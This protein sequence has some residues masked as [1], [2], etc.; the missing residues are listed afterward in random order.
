MYIKMNKDLSKFNDYTPFE[1]INKRIVHLEYTKKDCKDDF[2]I[3]L[4]KFYLNEIKKRYPNDKLETHIIYKLDADYLLDTNDCKKLEEIDNYLRENN[5]HELLVG[6]KNSEFHAHGFRAT[7][8]ANRKLD[9]VANNI[10]NATTKISGETKPLSNYE[11]LM[12]AY[13]Y[14]TN[15]V[16]NE[17]GDIGHVETSHWI[18]VIEG[19]KI[20]CAGY[21]SLFKALC[22]RIFDK[23]EVRVL[24]QSL[25]VFDIDTNE[26]RAGH[27]N[28][29]IF[30]KD[31]KYNIDGLFYIDP[32]WDSRNNTTRVDKQHAYF[33]IPLK[34]I[35]KSTKYTFSF[36][37]F[38]RLYLKQFEE[39]TSLHEN[40]RKSLE[41]DI[42][43]IFANFPYQDR[44]FTSYY[45]ERFNDLTIYS[46]YLNK[47]EIDSIFE[48]TK[49]REKEL[50]EEMKNLLKEKDIE[51]IHFPTFAINEL[52]LLPQINVLT[53]PT[54][55]KEEKDMATLFIADI[56]INN[57][58]ILKKLIDRGIEHNFSPLPLSQY[59][60]GVISSEEHQ[61]EFKSFR[62]KKEAFVKKAKKANCEKLISNLNKLADNTIPIE[63]PINAYKIVLEQEGVEYSKLDEIAKDRLNKARMRYEIEFDSD[64]SNHYLKRL[65]FDKKKKS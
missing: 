50:E 18:P 14:V 42:E 31:D 41:D 53:N 51:V 26:Y 56:L 58:E 28:N 59:L 20:V 17:G 32:C 30:L 62:R 52:N 24:E 44:D 48:Q 8:K 21:A 63:A 65:N 3:D 43:D 13:E 1:G 10:K 57:K 23:K 7:L 60:A 33:C 39:Y 15:Y 25:S 54:A 9:E 45:N 5:L 61:R 37:T 55:T 11:K 4:I 2:D 12:L 49:K 19:D 29:I 27:G 40:A 6:E 64:H 34:D 36:S 16:Y 47:E 22:D 38:I 46:K 35:L